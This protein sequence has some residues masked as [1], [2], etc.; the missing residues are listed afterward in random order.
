VAA[1][2][3]QKVSRLPREPGVYLWKDGH[4]ETLYIGKAVD[5]RARASSYFNDPAAKT[6]RLM[7]QAADIDFIA[8]RN[9]KE[10]LVLEQTLIKRNKPRYN[11]RL[12]DDKSYPYLKLTSGPYPRLV[13]TFRYVDDGGTYFGPFPDGY[14]AFHVLQVLSDLL[15]LRR[16]RTL[17]KHKCLYYDIGKCIAPCIA[18]CTDEEYALLV[19]ETKDILKGQAAGLARRVKNDMERAAAEHRFEDAA[20]LRDQMRGLEGVLERQHMTADSLEDRD[21]AA[22]HA[23]GDVAIVVLLHQRGGKIVGQSPFTLRGLADQAPDGALAEFLR[24]HYTDRT[25]P[26]HVAAELTEAVRAGLESDLRLLRGGAVTVE[27]PRRGE[28]RR[29][30][31]V[32][33]QNA[34]LRMEQEQERLRRRGMGAVEALQAAL[35]LE[36]PPRAI[37]GFDVSHQA[38]RHTRAALVRF[39]DGEPDKGGY[40]TFGMRTVGETAVRAGTAGATHGRGR[41]VDDY[42]SI[43]EAVLRRYRGVLGR[44]D[45]LPDLVLVDGGPGQLRAAREAL[46]ALG[47]DLRLA[48][49]AK[50]EEEVFVPGRLHPLRLRRDD[51]ALQ[52]LQRVRDEAH[53]SGIRQVRRKATRSVTASPLD[54]VPGI[55]PKKRAALLKAFAGL[56]GVRA[57][58]A[59]D[60]ARVPGIDHALAERV[61]EVLQANGG[62]D[63]RARTRT[64]DHDEAAA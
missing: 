30:L 24:G 31:E 58:S 2:L 39:V 38:G 8:V 45:P 17:P 52:L 53:R 60:M 12:T 48:S 49:L 16:C 18:A 64:G 7:E 19:A 9:E 11:I 54:D 56:A 36:V 55:G 43:A 35:G 46:A 22:L 63:G 32:A 6:Q 37:E 47:L 10:A 61:V 27:S 13:K 1:G 3:R 62:E 14:G 33:A 57:A 29:W 23:R 50:R 59:E 4:G 40:R 41:E 20:R 21:V 42:A 28:K 34:R 26:R 25:V 5:L 44:G 15:P 51:P